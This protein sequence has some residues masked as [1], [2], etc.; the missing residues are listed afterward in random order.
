MMM[1]MLLLMRWIVWIVVVLYEIRMKW[2]CFYE[3]MMWH[4]VFALVFVLDFDD[5]V[6]VDNVHVDDHDFY[7]RLKRSA[8]DGCSQRRRVEK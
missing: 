4:T 5:V 3:R 8:L 6:V 7:K 1:M 2:D